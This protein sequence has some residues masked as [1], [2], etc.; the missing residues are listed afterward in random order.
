LKGLRLEDLKDTPGAE[1][2]IA[3]PSNLHFL[4]P[5]RLIYLQFL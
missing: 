3:Y 2:A 5:S 4:K 1:S